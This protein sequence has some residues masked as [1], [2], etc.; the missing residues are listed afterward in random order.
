MGLPADAG[1]ILLFIGGGLRAGG[2]SIGRRSAAGGGILLFVGGGLRAG[3]ISMDLRAD[4]G[5]LFVGGAEKDRGGPSFLAGS[6]SIAQRP[7]SV[8]GPSS[9]AG[10][11]SVDRAC[12]LLDCGVEKERG[13]P[14]FRAG[15][16]S[17]GR[18]PDSDM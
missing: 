10:G 12:T 13:G 17:I 11:I 14:S 7:E 8:A 1:G 6:I 2:I 15:G 16:I 9:R 5:I 3:E 18:R 4:S